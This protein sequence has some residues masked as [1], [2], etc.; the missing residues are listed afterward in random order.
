MGQVCRSNRCRLHL[1]LAAAAKKRQRKQA[2]ETKTD[3]AAVEKVCACASCLPHCVMQ[4]R[5][6]T[7]VYEVES[8][9]SQRIQ[10]GVIQ[11]RVRWQGY[12]E[13]Q[14]SWLE[15]DRVEDGNVALAEFKRGRKKARGSRSGDQ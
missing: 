11:Y 4:Q 8:V 10:G 14:D 13:T 1:L 15:E 5:K 7:R 6:N 3:A 9:I 2:E 12:D